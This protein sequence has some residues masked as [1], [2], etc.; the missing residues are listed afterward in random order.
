MPPPSN[1]SATATQPKSSEPVRGSGFDAT[2]VVVAAAVVPSACTVV[3][4]NAV[5]PSGAVVVVE[6]ASV[7]TVGLV[8]VV[9]A[10]VVLASTDVVVVLGAVVLVLVEV[11]VVVGSVVVEDD[12][13]VVG[14]VVVLVEVLVDVLVLVEVDVDVVV[15]SIVVVVVVGSVVVDVLVLVDVLVV[16]DVDVL[17]EVDVLVVVVVSGTHVSV[18]LTEPSRVA[19]ELSGQLPETV[20][21]TVPLKLAPTVLVACTDPLV[22]TTVP[23]PAPPVRDPADT[24]MAV[25]VIAWSLSLLPIVH[26]MT[27][28]PFVQTVT[29]EMIG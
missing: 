1:A 19:V 10:I 25:I 8:V 14:S 27:C 5:V 11:D 13:V 24:E 28:S 20:S 17:V 9:V 3:V 18:T 4:T 21:V 2:V 26:V 6:I 15:G 7:V 23:T 29:P 16:V 12:V 22:G